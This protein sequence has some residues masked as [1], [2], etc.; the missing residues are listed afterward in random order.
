MDEDVSVAV[1]DNSRVLMSDVLRDALPREMSDDTQALALNYVM[2]VLGRVIDGMESPL[3]G[4]LEGFMAQGDTIEVEAKVELDEALLTMTGAPSA[5][6]RRNI[7]FVFVE[8]HD[9]EKVSAFGGESQLELNG[10]RLGA[11][12]YRR[13]MCVL[14]LNLRRAT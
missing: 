9:G 1:P 3:V 12:D 4:T 10:V 8:L 14:M 5:N 2:V 7:H 6:P 11:I 13:R